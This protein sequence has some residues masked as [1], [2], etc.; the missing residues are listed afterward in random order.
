MIALKWN[1]D[2]IEMEWRLRRNK[3]TIMME[4]NG[5]YAKTEWQ[6]HRYRV[7]RICE[8]FGNGM[9]KRKNNFFFFL[10]FFQSCYKGYSLHDYKLKNT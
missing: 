1:G 6:L 4:W 7:I 5:E 3:M 10:S 8:L 9:H 2:H